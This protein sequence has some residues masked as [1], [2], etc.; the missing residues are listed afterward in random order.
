MAL[1]Y[2]FDPLF[3]SDPNPDRVEPGSVST[4]P[5]RKAPR[6]QD[7]N[8]NELNENDRMQQCFVRDI[9]RI[10]PIRIPRNFKPETHGSTIS[11]YGLDGNNRTQPDNNKSLCSVRPVRSP[12]A[13]NRASRCAARS[14][15]RRAGHAVPARSS[16]ASQRLQAARRS[17]HM[18]QRPSA[19]HRTAVASVRA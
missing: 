2:S 12:I 9:R 15:D 8:Q 17:L 11:R 3:P 10:R 1:Q 16:R 7:T 18:S 4:G 14:T 5:R 19:R 6:L 13:V